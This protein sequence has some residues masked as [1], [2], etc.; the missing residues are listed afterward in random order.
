VLVCAGQDKAAELLARLLPAGNFEI[1][2]AQDAAAVS[3]ILRQGDVDL[4]LLDPAAPGPDLAEVLRKARAVAR[5]AP[6][7]LLADDPAARAQAALLR[8]VLDS[9]A[10]AIVVVAEGGDLVY[11]NSAAERLLGARP[12]GLAAQ[13]W[14]RGQDLRLPDRVTPC[15]AEERP[16]ARALRGEVVEAAEV[17]LAGASP[18]GVWLSSDARPLRD[19]AGAVRGAVVTYRDITEQKRLQEQCLQAQKMEAVGQL[20]GG[21]AHDFNNLLTI[22]NGYSEVLHNTLRSDDPA[23]V[24]LAEIRKAGER[25]AALTRQLLAV[26]RKQVLESRPLDLNALVGDAA[27]MLG[28]IIS[29][30]IT[31]ETCLEPHL[32]QV[33]ADPGQIDQVLLN[34][35]VNAR[36]AMPEGGKL[37]IATANAMRDAAAVRTQPAARPGPYVV[38]AV[39]DSGCGMSADVQAHLFE[40]FFTTKGP[41]KG[42]GL[43]LATVFG[44][45]TQSGGHIEVASAPGQG[46]TFQIYLPRC[47]EPG[48]A[49]TQ[50]TAPPPCTSRGT[51]TILLVEDDEG[52]RTLSRQVLAHQGYTVLDAG[53]GQEALQVCAA[54]A[55]P[56][57]LLVADVVMP[58]LGGRELARRLRTLHPQL[59]VLYLSGYPD[60][61]AAL[62]G[63]VQAEEASLLH[64]PFTPSALLSKVR[65]ILEH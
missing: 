31:L 9:T 64:K 20:A 52:V 58:Q 21:V 17:F 63:W 40:P 24:L 42:T 18:G 26:S 55:Q 28:R 38:L 4:V 59:R 39:T 32:G 47:P 22:M 48:P 60:D 46:T 49:P 25:G 35:A 37:T 57:H 61:A 36:D 45:V 7:L 23:R 3:T 43:G 44:I 19:P 10:E 34:L 5:P 16:L 53:H 6:V 15:P 30:T 2:A 50:P 11:C 27:R 12:G 29:E 13:E 8:A 33:L 65:E 56:I 54:H 62:E 1:M 41:G 51:E 14:L